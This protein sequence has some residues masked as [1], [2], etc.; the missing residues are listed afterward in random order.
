M[1]LSHVIHMLRAWHRYRLCVRE[2]SQLSDLELTD[3][4]L[5]RSGIIFVAWRTA[6]D[7]LAGADSASALHNEPPRDH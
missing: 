6:Q 3:I 1:I 2:L 7:Y 4:G 5:T